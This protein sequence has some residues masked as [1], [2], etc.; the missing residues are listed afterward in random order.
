M[1]ELLEED[2][3]KADEEKTHAET[4]TMQSPQFGEIAV[5]VMPERFRP[6]LKKKKKGTMMMVVIVV[7]FVLIAIASIIALI[8][9]TQ[10]QKQ[11]KQAKQQ[12]E[13]NQQSVE[14]NQSE[15]SISE[16]SATS[17]D[18]Q[19]STADSSSPPEQPA[20]PLQPQEQK[21]VSQNTQ[22]PSTLESSAPSLVQG[23]D[24][25]GDVLTDAEERMY[26]TDPSKPDTDGDGFFD[27]EEFKKLFDPTKATQ[28]RL[29]TSILTH[30]YTNQPFKYRILYPAAWIAKAV[31]AAEREVIF[32]SATGE[33]MSLT[34]A[35]NPKGLSPLDWYVTAKDPGVNPAQLQT[36]AGDTWS[37]VVSSDG[38]SIYMSRKQEKG[39]SSS[40]PVMYSLTYNLNAKNEVHFLTTFQMMMKSFTFTDLTFIK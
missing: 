39:K 30:T 9:L 36:I 2:L 23:T 24:T 8:V 15:Q 12:P 38:R 16:K 22:P 20:T 25:D 10:P 35:D 17:T 37:G 33:F 7:L 19:I 1:F 26:G 5:S 18:A 32:T 11:T 13:A 4:E 29:D 28:I 40:A 14:S 27:G 21:N 31:N 3:A 6:I 34:V